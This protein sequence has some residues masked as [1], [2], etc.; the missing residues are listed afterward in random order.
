MDYR[1]MSF[2]TKFFVRRL[3]TSLVLLSFCGLLALIL[4]S[5][6]GFLHQKAD[7][8]SHFRLHYS[9]ALLTIIGFLFI[10]K[11]YRL[12]LAGTLLLVLNTANAFSYPTKI[13]TADTRE[14]PLKVITLNMLF[15]ANNERDI[16]QLVRKERP[17]ILLLQEAYRQKGRLLAALKKDYPWQESCT[18]RKRC[19]VAIL[20]KL[21][22]KEAGSGNKGKD[23][24]AIAWAKF[25][26]RYGNVTIASVH[27]RWPYYS[28]QRSQ[29]DTIFKVVGNSRSPL[30]IGGDFNATPWSW[31]MRSFA[32]ANNL[33]VAGIVKPTWPVLAGSN[34]RCMLCVP[35]LP[36]DHVLVSQDVRVASR[37]NGPS[38]RSDHLPVIVEIG[39]PRWQTAE[40]S[41]R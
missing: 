12:M 4:V 39:V 1:M 11:S 25:G 31:T 2:Y 30:V 3:F 14:L 9:V 41:L 21:P 10:L 7:A 16:V 26:A 18:G 29:L 15:G 23:R 8:F 37:R 20:S 38:V 13:A 40:S 19:S 5:H 17:D 34:R 36:I 28:N 6:L 24:L 32:E 27:V 35:Q 33:S 22:W